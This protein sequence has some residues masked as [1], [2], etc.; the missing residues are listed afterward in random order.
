MVGLGLYPQ[1]LEFEV[2]SKERWQLCPL[3]GSEGLHLYGSKVVG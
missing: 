1:R 2:G 3:L